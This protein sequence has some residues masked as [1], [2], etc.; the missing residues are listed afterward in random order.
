MD[1]P[2]EL[3]R[4][5]GKALEKDPND[6]YQHIEELL[7]DLRRLRR[8]QNAG[9][10]VTQGGSRRVSVPAPVSALSSAKR[11]AGW[12]R[13]PPSVARTP[14]V[15]QAGLVL[16]SMVALVFATLYFR[17]ETPKAPLVR[18]AY[19]HP[20]DT[21]AFFSS[22]VTVSPNGRHI[23]FVGESGKLWVQDLDQQSP[24]VLDGTEGATDPFW[25]P[26]SNF[27]GFATRTELKRVPVRGGP[28]TRICALSATMFV[29]GS[30][31]AR[32]LIVFG[33]GSPGL[34]YQVSA[35]GGSP[36]PVFSQDDLE[37]LAQ[38]ASTGSAHSIGFP[39]FLP[40]GAGPRVMVF[41]FGGQGAATIISHDFE[42][43]QQKVLAEGSRPVFSTSGHLLHQPTPHS[44]EIWALPFSLESLEP[45]AE[46]FLIAQ[47][48]R[49]HTVSVDGTLVY[50]DLPR[51]S[52]HSLI[53]LNRRGEKTGELGSGE[54]VWDLKVSP[55]GQQVAVTALQD[56]N[57]D[58]WVYDV[59]Q[60]PR[61]RVT[62]DPGVEYRPS[63]SPTGEELAY[64]STRSGDYD[65]F[66]RRADGTGEEIV[67][68]DHESREVLN[69]W[70]R[71]GRYL[72][73]R[74]NDPKTG[75]D[76]WYLERDRSGGGWAR[77]PFLR[78][79]FSEG[80]AS[81]SPDAK[82]VAY[83]SDE[84]GRREIY[85]RSFPSGAKWPVSRNGGKHPTWSADGEEIFFLEGKR[86]M[87]ASV[88]VGPDFAVNSVSPLFEHES[89]DQQ[90]F[91][92]GVSPDGERFLVREAATAPPKPAIRVVQNWY[93]E[94]R[95]REQN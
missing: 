10:F 83:R 50:H 45:T 19:T 4:I 49:R 90:P 84:S 3:D 69:D 25:S 47:N 65:I 5:V 91:T 24:R 38:E 88:S 30:W 77:R 23:A 6:R 52:L 48:A 26:G 95:D 15:L 57:R 54:E 66:L 76:L 32:D 71:D 35:H 72:I 94:F 33:N 55:S 22:N 36:T 56:S 34:L 81:F 63:W 2:T 60:G 53:W 21:G 18:F 75:T 70:S 82:F 12:S 16:T 9:S 17:Q 89:F 14:R 11:R 51:G 40:A 37:R 80:R 39:H 41:S 44:G 42:S 85:V 27:I 20:F 93:Q 62:S 78:T 46:P 68:A 7:V 86:L 29:G 43:G 61:I 73:Y 8:G 87:A 59:A 79:E 74:L 1:V 64:S 58:V 28:V 13:L 92:Y 67:L 31:S